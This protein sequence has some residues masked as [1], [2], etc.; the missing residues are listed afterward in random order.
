MGADEQVYAQRTR[1]TR[2][3]PP[4]PTNTGSLAWENTEHKALDVTRCYPY[5]PG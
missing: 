1:G 2:G 3:L 5:L 4:R